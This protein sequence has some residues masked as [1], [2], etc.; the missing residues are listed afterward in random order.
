MGDLDVW[1]VE[2]NKPH[3][4]KIVIRLFKYPD[5]IVN[6]ARYE[7]LHIVFGGH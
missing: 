4:L 5:F 7:H 3:N 6:T 1:A 2:V